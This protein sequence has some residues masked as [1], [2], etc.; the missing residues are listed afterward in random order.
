MP[1]VFVP[2]WGASASLYD[3]PSPW[4]VL[5]PPPFAGFETI[6]SRVRWLLAQLDG[7]GPVTL[8]GHSMGGALAALAAGERPGSV[9]R[10]VL[11]EPAGLP[12]TKPLVAS[13]ATFLGQ[14]ATRTYPWGE[15]RRAA[16]AVLAS[17]RAALRLATA[18][19]S[20]DLRPHLRALHGRLPV[21]VVSCT[22]DTLTTTR[23]CRRL[24]LLAG[25]RY[26]ELDLP[27]GHM[28]MLREP[29]ALAAVLS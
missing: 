5:E 12:L 16:A 8:A 19:R 4:V 13:A 18:V 17:P 9:R 7:H 25:A 15:A 14:L 2:G 6:E 11:I 24:A 27:G 3:V 22:S 28:W 23:H 26:R 1:C 21:D 20:L 29:A 10:L